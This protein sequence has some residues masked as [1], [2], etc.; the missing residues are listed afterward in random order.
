MEELLNKLTVKLITYFIN[1]RCSYFTGED[2]ECDCRQLRLQQEA[3]EQQMQFRQHL[4]QLYFEDSRPS[5]THTVNDN[6]PSISN[7]NLPVRLAPTISPAAVVVSSVQQQQPG[8]TSHLDELSLVSSASSIRK[9][10]NDWEH[11]KDQLNPIDFEEWSESG[12]LGKLGQM[13][14]APLYLLLT[15]TI[16]VVDQENPLDNWCRPLNCIHILTGPLVIL[17]LTGS[18]STLFLE[19]AWIFSIATAA[20]AA[21]AVILYICTTSLETPKGHFLFAYLGFAVSVVWIYSLANEV[22]SDQA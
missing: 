11:L 21:G 19:H 2:P 7:S 17:L 14:K 12:I 22:V 13:L 4:R 5:L 15:I 8:S 20:L 6:S 3:A 1:S 10:C 16:P 9:P 18:F